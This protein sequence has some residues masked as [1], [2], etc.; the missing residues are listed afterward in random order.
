MIKKLSIVAFGVIAFLLIFPLLSFIYQS[1]LNIDS[2]LA[3]FLSALSILLVIILTFLS[4]YLDNRTNS[5][6]YNALE[7]DELKEELHTYL[8]SEN[9]EKLEQNTSVS[10]A[11]LLQDTLS[12]DLSIP[13]IQKNVSWFLDQ[14]A[15]YETLMID[16]EEFEQNIYSYQHFLTQF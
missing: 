1:L 13:L 2:S 16:A 7:A 4:D 3:S 10:L 6:H 5:E 11:S 8:S 9:L 15:A 14:L 12:L